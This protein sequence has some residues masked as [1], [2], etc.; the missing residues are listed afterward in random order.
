MLYWKNG[1]ESL[2]TDE[3][4]SLSQFLIQKFHT[5]SR[6]A[7]YSSTGIGLFWFKAV[8]EANA[9]LPTCKRVLNP[10]ML[11]LKDPFLFP[12]PFR[13]KRFCLCGYHSFCSHWFCLPFFLKGWYN[14]LYI[15]FTLR[16]HIFFFLLQ[17]YFPATLM[18]MLSWVSFWIDR[19]AVP[20]R[21]SLGESNHNEAQLCEILQMW[22]CWQERELFILVV[23]VS[24]ETT[25][26]YLI[27]NVMQNLQFALS[28]SSLSSLPD[29]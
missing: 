4:I 6:L 22:K 13:N 17:T 7:F 8:A 23:K 12:L 27:I 26:F 21:V 14:R 29:L 28:P 9:V 24:G 25:V 11:V 19:R 10:P 1:N 2:K 16:R 3:K 5:T 18:V 20:A 15:S